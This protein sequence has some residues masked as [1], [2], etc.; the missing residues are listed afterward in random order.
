MLFL[1]RRGEQITR[2][3]V[4]VVDTA[5]KNGDYKMDHYSIAAKTG[6]AQIPQTRRWV[7]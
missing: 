2:M 7:L 5:L 3:L 1:K 4:H 6:T